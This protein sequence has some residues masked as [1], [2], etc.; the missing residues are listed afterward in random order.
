MLYSV[1]CPF[2][3]MSVV[4][5]SIS[6]VVGWCGLFSNW[7]DHN[8]YTITVHLNAWYRVFS[9][10]PL[11]RISQ[12][13]VYSNLWLLWSQHYSCLDFCQMNQ[14]SRGRNFS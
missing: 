1:C 2:A 14:L 5:Y 10:S 11:S 6:L 9:F 3:C 8:L 12:T 7:T 4:C 13:F